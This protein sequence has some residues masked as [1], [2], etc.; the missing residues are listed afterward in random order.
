MRVRQSQTIR[1]H[2]T[3]IL[4]SHFIELRTCRVVP[5]FCIWG[6]TVTLSCSNAI[7]AYGTG[8]QRFSPAA[9][10]PY[11]KITHFA[12]RGSRLVLLVLID[13][14]RACCEIPASCQGGPIIAFGG[15]YAI[16]AN[17]AGIHLRSHGG[18]V[19]RQSH[20]RAAICTKY[21]T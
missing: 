8:F 20:R 10:D 12:C 11:S 5:T 6:V 4:W 7:G 21:A 13:E 9:I 14:L 15:S 18:R 3:L 16:R 17:D 1:T 2:T 19:C